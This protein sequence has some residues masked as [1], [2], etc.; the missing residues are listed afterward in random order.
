M[1]QVFTRKNYLAKD[2]KKPYFICS[3][4]M[5]I[6][7]EDMLIKKMREY[8]STITEADMRAVLSVLRIIVLRSAGQGY[9]VQV[10]FGTVW[11]VAGGSCQTIDETYSPGGKGNDHTLNIHFRS[12]KSVRTE[13]LS[14]AEIERVSSVFV[15]VPKI[16]GA[17]YLDVNGNELPVVK[18]NEQGDEISAATLKSGDTLRIKGEYLKI[19]AADEKQG[20]FLNDI[21]SEKKIRLGKYTRNGEVIVD[22]TIPADAAAGTYEVEL[23]T[24]PGVDRYDHAV[25]PDRVI[26]G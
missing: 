16:E 9:T 22:S 21:A 23:V 3:R 12:T 7:D 11:A 24:Q 5:N 2:D 17:F 10:P 25:S 1:L 18:R 14:S 8:N 20:V 4:T 26:I 15:Q 6:M 19:D 13:L